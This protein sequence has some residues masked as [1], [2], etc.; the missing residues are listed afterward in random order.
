MPSPYTDS[1]RISNRACSFSVGDE[2]G[3]KG[4]PGVAVMGSAIFARAAI[5]LRWGPLTGF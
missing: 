2:S 4:L 5:L 1:V 3:K